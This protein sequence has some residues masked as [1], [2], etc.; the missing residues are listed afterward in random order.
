MPLPK[1]TAVVTLRGLNQ[2]A[3]GTIA[4]PGELELAENVYV[5]RGQPGAFEFARRNGMTQIGT[6]SYGAGSRLGSMAEGLLL[7]GPN[8]LEDYSTIMGTV[9][10]FFSKFVPL[11]LGRN[12]LNTPSPIAVGASSPVQ[13]SLDVAFY[14]TTACYIWIDENSA[15]FYLIYD[16][17]SKVVLSTGTLVA[18]GATHA[19]CVVLGTNF[20]VF[21]N[22][23][24]SSNRIRAVS[25]SATTL[26]IG[27]VTTVIAA[28]LAA[29]DYDIFTGF[30]STHI[31]LLY[32][33]AAGT[34]TRVLVDAAYALTASTDDATAANQP[35]V[36]MCWFAQATFPGNIAYATINA[37]NGARVQTINATTLASVSTFSDTDASLATSVNWTGVMANGTIPLL[38]SHIPG[39]PV[40]Q[41]YV[42]ESGNGF[43]QPIARSV[44]LASRAFVISSSIYIWCL[45][46]SASGAIEPQDTYVL[47]DLTNGAPASCVA[48]SLPA[49]AAR[50]TSGH[51]STAA[52]DSTGVTHML[53]QRVISAES[54]AGALAIQY[55]I[56]DISIGPISQLTGGA[57]NFGGVELWP[58][59]TILELDGSRQSW[60]DVHEQNFIVHPEPVILA[61]GAPASGSVSPGTRSI[62]AV[63]K[64][65]DRNGQIARSSPST[66][67]AITTVNA[68][69]SIS[70]TANTHKLG[71]RQYVEIEIYQTPLNGIGDQYFRVSPSTFAGVATNLT[72]VFISTA[73][74]A[75]LAA[76]E[77]LV[78]SSAGGELENVGPR[79]ANVLCEHK[80]RVFGVISEQPHRIQFTKEYVV[81]TSLG[82]FDG[83]VINTPETT[84]RIYALASM[85]GHL[86]AIKRDCAYVIDGDFPD[87]DGGGPAMPLP[88]LIPTGVGT[89]DPRSVCVSELGVHFHSRTK[90]FW[91]IDRGLSAQYIGSQV[92]AQANTGSVVVSGA[93]VMSNLT[94][95]RF[96]SEGGTTFVLDTFFAKLGNPV[97]TTFT[98]QPCVHSINHLGR[99]YQLTSD[100]KL[101]VENAFWRD[102][103]QPGEQG[104]FTNGTEYFGKVTISDI[105]FAGVLGLVRVW[106]GQI[107]GEWKAGHNLKITVYDNHKTSVGD[108]YTFTATSNPDPYMMEF[109]IR[110]QKVTSKRI[111]IEEVTT[112]AQQTQGALW[113]AVA[114]SLGVKP[115]MS[116]LPQTKTMVGA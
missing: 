16:N 77:E 100:G 67:V 53:G 92:E 116:R 76:G 70:V 40:Y 68:N 54:S 111:T 42:R 82:F 6:I 23:A 72:Q 108:T 10:P 37:A 86:L 98:G 17:V 35:D 102:G 62:V 43:T 3:P 13:T 80:N 113:T 114:F 96:T 15:V 44:G 103:S 107:L 5:S 14:Q 104:T 75:T 57:I 95:V 18:S 56:S 84:G 45:Y 101:K 26:A 11:E 27:S 79:A 47:Y 8:T 59:A 22:E 81:G 19:R 105:N 74:E 1:Q 65:L 50:L 4:A 34:Y 2:S 12:D 21:W 55:G 60:G 99:W 36:G 71:Y 20:F 52:M 109:R 24:A 78:P 94:Q 87:A 49:Q 46:N 48:V 112:G 64:W 66:P 30:D 51:L 115:G 90:G 91:I 41:T 31:A 85:D 97:W 61:E 39:S 89:T 9:G 63:Y 93:A 29:S 106:R 73:S 38:F 32:R 88:L 83:F 25:I 58:G 28:P 7:R 69:S 33:K 110:Y